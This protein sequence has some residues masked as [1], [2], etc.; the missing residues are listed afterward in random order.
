M[1]A[2]FALSHLHAPSFVPLFVLS[3]G[4][5]LA[6]EWT[7]SLLA[8]VTMHALFNTIMMIRLLLLRMQT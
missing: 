1:S 8:P 4:L 2:A 5:G 7:G 6:Y 3:I